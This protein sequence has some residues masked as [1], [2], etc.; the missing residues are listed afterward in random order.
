M[1]F[2]LIEP[3]TES[4]IENGSKQPTQ[5]Q[6]KA[7]KV[8][9]KD[10]NNLVKSCFKR[11]TLMIVKIVTDS[12]SNLPA[13]IARELG[14][15]VVPIYICIGDKRYRDGIDISPDELYQRL[16]EGPDYPTTI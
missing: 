11:K 12:G 9:K 2:A 16:I 1:E 3:A 7:V 6:S 8:C 5:I 15:T 10:Y 13:D 4:A 14:I